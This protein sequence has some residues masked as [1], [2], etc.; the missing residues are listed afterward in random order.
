MARQYLASDLRLH[1]NSFVGGTGPDLV[2]IKRSI[3]ADN[4]RNQ[5]WT[6]RWLRRFRLLNSPLQ[7][8]RDRERRENHKKE[9][10]PARDSLLLFLAAGCL[11]PVSLPN[12]GGGSIP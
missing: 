11:H 2:Q 8:F 6:D 5:D 7:S 10:S 1:L 12:F 9:N 4:F 3:L